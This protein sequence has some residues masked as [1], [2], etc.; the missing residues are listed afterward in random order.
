MKKMCFLWLFMGFVTM[1]QAQDIAPGQQAQGYLDGK[2]ATVDYSTGIFHYKVPLYTLGNG[3]F[4]LP[5]SLDYAGKGVKR[6]EQPGLIGYNWTLNTGGVVTRTIRG[7]I[8]DEASFN[9]Y[10]YYLQKADAVSLAED[11]K[12]V[13]RHQRDGESDIFTVVFN[14]QSVHFILGLDGDGRICALPLERTNVKIEC[15]QRGI[16]TIDGWT[17]TDEEGNRYIYRQKEYSADIV[18]EDA[19]SFNG[20]RG[21][22]YVSSWYLSRIEPVNGSPLIY[23]YLADVRQ[24]GTQ[25]N[26]Q[27]SYLTS[28]YRTHYYYGRNLREHTFDFEP[29][30]AD[31]NE[32]ISE[33]RIYLNSF[34]LEMQLDNSLYE[35]TRAGQWVRNPNFEQGAQAIRNNFRVMGQLADFRNISAASNELINVLNDL[36]TIYSAQSSH[37]AQMAAS[38]FRIA[39]SYV[40]QSLEQV[41]A[42]SEREVGNGTSLTVR[43]PLLSQI[44]CGNN[45]IR[46]G[47]SSSC[48]DIRLTSLQFGTVSGMCFAGVE[49]KNDDHLNRISFTGRDSTRNHTLDFEYYATP[50]NDYYG[51]VDVWGYY[52]KKGDPNELDGALGY[53]EYTRISSLKSITLSNGGRIEIDYEQNKSVPFQYQYRGSSFLTDSVRYGGLRLKSLV[54]QDGIS[55]SGDTVLY[56]YP[57]PGIPVYPEIT[58]SEQLNY[59]NFSDRLV[60]SRMKFKGIAFLNTGNNGLYY[61]Q[62]EELRPG[63][64][65]R[66]YLFHVPFSILFP[67]YEKYYPLELVGLP[68]S[69]SEYDEEGHL[70]RSVHNHYETDYSIF[71]SGL[72]LNVNKSYFSDCESGFRYTGQYQQL[73]ADENYMDAEYL[74][75]YY[76]NQ[77]KVLIY[78]D[79]NSSCYLDPYN[80]VYVPNI[81][82]RTNRKSSNVYYTLYYGG[83][84]LL[85][86]QK[87]YR[88]PFQDSK[89]ELFITTEYFYDNPTGSVRP[90]RIV[91]TDACGDCYT[92]VT[93]RVTEM[94]VAADT[95]LS[96][97]VSANMLALPVKQ[98]LLKN[99]SLLTETVNVYT[100]VVGNMRRGVGVKARYSY[101]PLQPSDYQVNIK[102]PTLFTY[103]QANYTQEEE[104]EYRWWQDVLSLS[105][106]RT[107]TSET[108]FFYDRNTDASL[109]EVASTSSKEMSVMD[110]HSLSEHFSGGKFSFSNLIECHIYYKN[111]YK[112]LLAVP[113]ENDTFRQYLSSS[114]QNMF[115][116]LIE[117]VACNRTDAYGELPALCDSVKAHAGI[118][119]QFLFSCGRILEEY[120]P[121][122]AFPMINRAAIVVYGSVDRGLLSDPFFLNLGEI[123]PDDKKANAVLSVYAAA[124]TD[125]LTLYAVCKSGNTN[126]IW[127]I[128]H[129]GGVTSGSGEIINTSGYSLQ[130]FDIDLSSFEGVDRVS[131][132]RSSLNNGIHYIALLPAGVPFQA[133]SYNADGTVFCRFDQTGRME[134]NEYDSAGRLVRVLDQDGH[135]LESYEHHVVN[136]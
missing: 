24:S 73:R 47:Y 118:F 46:F 134:V 31:F 38:W 53:I 116:R 131:I 91:Q 123:V 128:H 19:V 15:E 98:V 23:H 1:L 112:A 92:E 52:G 59:G 100:T 57:Y 132:S 125:S 25:D 99:D 14:G 13:N 104:H 48:Y 69:M 41:E 16:H 83:K 39:K 10:L 35:F 56:R 75:N 60:H 105:D 43:G 110:L 97:M 93:T 127:N 17:V 54:F 120:V 3:G 27:I 8:A 78:R 49:L 9:G 67:G 133:T 130:R 55:A 101:V 61:R 62:V 4:S 71:F 30:L 114:P 29:F 94:D 6:D 103:G 42:V 95:S 22:T 18:K 44:V 96:H 50:S 121:E 21:K 79:G 85:K 12:N 80:H 109:L 107:R 82:P 28:R 2:N 113:E 117:I 76:R 72:D 111:F 33:A 58:N 64:G 90:T 86:S 126:L 77:A 37:N 40:I 122:D 70:L 87:E 36:N 129:S 51:A 11:A 68:L 89:G 63:Q 32:A 74:E 81:E 119:N 65:K 26:I 66:S 34:S 136:P 102:N 88:Y 5:V 115:C 84:T 124:D 7:G 20:L 106:S 108:A 135:L 45:A